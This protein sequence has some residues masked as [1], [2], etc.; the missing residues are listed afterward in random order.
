MQL[1]FKFHSIFGV[2]LSCYLK[3]ITVPSI[4]VYLA[5]DID[6]FG[7]VSQDPWI[8]HMTIRENILFGKPFY[9]KEYFEVIKC[10]ALQEVW[11]SILCSFIQSCFLV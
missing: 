10:C 2:V 1:I 7:F 6:G 8:Q 11:F 5:D 9:H 4:Q 3:T